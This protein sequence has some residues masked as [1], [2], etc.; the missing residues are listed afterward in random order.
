M[1][2]YFGKYINVDYSNADAYNFYEIISQEELLEPL[3]GKEETVSY[4]NYL[5]KRY[6]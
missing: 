6:W 4:I 5:S 2:K 3:I 1:R